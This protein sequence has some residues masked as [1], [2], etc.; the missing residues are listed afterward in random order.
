[1]DKKKHDKKM[2][3]KTKIILGVCITLALL[4]VALITGYFYARGKIYSK[5]DTSISEKN[6]EESFEEVPGITNILLIGTDAREL[7]EHARSDS[8][9]IATIDNNNKKLKLSSIMRDTFVDIP[10]YGEQKINAA[11]ALG[12]PELLIKTIKENFNFNLDKYVMIN[13]WGFENVIDGIGGIDVEVKDYEIS[14]INK[15]IGE[16]DEVKSPPLT[17]PGMQHL[18]GQQTLSY[19]R[20]RK[21][22]NGSYERTE[23]Q[24]RVLNIVAEEMMK[25]SVLKYPGM[26]YDLL[27]SV[28]TNVEP[29]TLLNYAYTVSKFGDLKFEQLQVPATDL[30]EG[31][32]YRNKGWVFLIDKEQNSQMLYDFI[33]NDKLPT[34]GSFDMKKFKSVMDNYH[35]L[36]AEYMKIHGEPAEK[37]ETQDE[38]NSLKNNKNDFVKV[39]ELVGLTES[40][41]RE[42]IKNA[43]LKVG[44]V[45]TVNISQESKDGLVTS[46]LPGSG[47]TVEKG[48][49]VKFTIGRYVKEEKTYNIGEIINNSMTG[50]Q[51]KEAL[52]AKELVN[53][54][55]KVLEGG[56]I[57]TG[58]VVN[59]TPNEAKKGDK[60][61][62][63]VK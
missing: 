49:V 37:E 58:K 15:Y 7:N 47:S 52:I 17:A 43:G 54:E 10:G 8:I 27:P 25:V 46:V 18:D 16:V 33:Y 12:G 35:A 11:L 24:R 60:I 1:M 32:L 22:G 30:S 56:N 6:G 40:A 61:I 20:I 53:V 42:A 39:P 14:E 38:I 21:V 36:N 29:L 48:S 23:R 44:T 59:W 34:E 62:I 28:Q 45:G 4:I 41:A 2:S 26:L 57:D 5:L 51:A 31:G 19:A 50:N 63:Y 9:I 13:F 3:K 55:I